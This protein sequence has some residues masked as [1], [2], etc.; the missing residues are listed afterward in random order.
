VAP[1]V[2]GGSVVGL[3]HA[4]TYASNRRLHEADRATLRSFADG[5]GLLL[6]RLALLERL[7]LQRRQIAE[8]LAAATQMVDDL[9]VAPVLLVADAE[10]VASCDPVRASAAPHDRLTT[11]EREVFSLLVGGATNAEIANRLTVSETTVKSHVKHI[12]RKLRAANRS[13]AIAKYLAMS[14]ARGLSS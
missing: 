7:D 6:E 4:D 8:A 12:L 11:R 14:G 13:E 9:C 1:V 10:P 3:L 5:I 2:S